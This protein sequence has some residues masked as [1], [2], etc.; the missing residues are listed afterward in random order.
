MI[1]LRW[2]NIYQLCRG[3]AEVCPPRPGMTDP[4]HD[5]NEGEEEEEDRLF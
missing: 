4:D 5:T 2:N 1:V 3:E